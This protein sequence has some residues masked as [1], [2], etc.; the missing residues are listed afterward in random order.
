MCPFICNAVFSCTYSKKIFKAYG[1]K[2]HVSVIA[3]FCEC[4][5][6]DLNHVSDLCVTGLVLE[7][8]K[9]YTQR[10]VEQPFHISM[11]TL[12]LSS[13]DNSGRL[14][15]LYSVT[16]YAVAKSYCIFVFIV[17]EDSVSVICRKQD[18]DF[19]LCNLSK[20]RSIYNVPLNLDFELGGEISFHVSGNGTV[21]LTGN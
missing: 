17:A 1:K 6:I 8:K 21:H 20:K 2:Q 5:A 3:L 15:G 12:D 10:E 7:P 9:T 16:A 11:A 4:N 13:C 14:F 19:I 18:A